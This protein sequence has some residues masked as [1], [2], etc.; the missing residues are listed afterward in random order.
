M[1][2]KLALR[3][4]SEKCA[5]GGDLSGLPFQEFPRGRHLESLDLARLVRESMTAIY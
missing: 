1:Q 2:I 4:T 5:I 3:E